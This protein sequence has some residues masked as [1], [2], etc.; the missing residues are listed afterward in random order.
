MEV[1]AG[2]EVKELVRKQRTDPISRNKRLIGSQILKSLSQPPV[3]I[4]EER[5]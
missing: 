1:E 2:A 4:P 5:L 3:K